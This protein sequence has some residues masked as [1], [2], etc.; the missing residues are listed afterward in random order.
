MTF[1]RAVE[2]TM[3][4]TP[5]LYWED[6][7]VGDET[8]FG[9]YTVSEQEIIE[10][11]TKYDPL[12]HHTCIK[13]ASQTPL[14]TLIASGLQVIGVAHRILVDNLFIRAGIVAGTGFKNMNI[15]SPVMPGDTLDVKMSVEEKS[16]HPRREDQGWI[17]FKINVFSQNKKK[18]MDY[19][20]S[21]LFLKRDF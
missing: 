19:E 21:M 6:F 9:N 15:H 1:N 3:S 5:S 16:N 4:L 13:L 12:P 7:V 10:F 14:G 17:D 20:I 2:I 18:V 8:R 11:G